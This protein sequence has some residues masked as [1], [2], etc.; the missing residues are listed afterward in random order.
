MGVLGADGLGTC[1]ELGR[2]GVTLGLAQQS[3]VIL[4]DHS[5]VRMRRPEHL[6]PDGQAALIKRFGFDILTLGVIEPSNPANGSFTS[7]GN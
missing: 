6:F 7:V 4:Q 2:L 5:D 1:L 3:G